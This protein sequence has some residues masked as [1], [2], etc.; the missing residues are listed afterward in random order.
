M[1][2]RTNK[3]QQERHLLTARPRRSITLPEVGHQARRMVVCQFE[4]F[5]VLRRFCGA[6]GTAKSSVF[7]AGETISAVAATQRLARAVEGGFLPQ[8]IRRDS[9]LDRLRLNRKHR[10]QAGSML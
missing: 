2:F 9:T 5:E 10:K 6:W 4:G 7:A 8:T 3:I 1:P